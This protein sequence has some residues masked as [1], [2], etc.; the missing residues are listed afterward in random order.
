MTS[1]PDS[2]QDCARAR[3]R[4]QD[5]KGDGFGFPREVR[6]TEA[7]LFGRVFKK[8]FRV[9][10]RF[11]LVLARPNQ[12]QSSRL[13]MAI[14]K[15]KIRKAVGRNRIKRLIRESFRVTKRTLPPVDLVVMA[16]AGA[17]KADNRSLRAELD[18][19]WQV[20]GRKFAVTNNSQSDPSHS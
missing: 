19:H 10:G 3:D 18:E 13:G 5:S 12:T 17:H 15:K 4:K 1:G 6:L 7:A 20:I 8:A 9:R 11:L 16:Q 14:A 2:V